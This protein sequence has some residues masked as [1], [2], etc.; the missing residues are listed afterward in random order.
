MRWQM[1]FKLNKLC[2]ERS[3]SVVVV[4]VFAVFTIG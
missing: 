4:L 2:K 1:R 3:E